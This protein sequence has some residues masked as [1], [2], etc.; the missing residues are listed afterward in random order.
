MDDNLDSH[1]KMRKVLEEGLQP[2]IDEITYAKDPFMLEYKTE[3]PKIG[4]K[5]KEFLDDEQF[6]FYCA[7]NRVLMAFLTDT[8][9]RFIIDFFSHG[10]KRYSMFME[11]N[12]KLT[13]ATLL[14]GSLIRG[15]VKQSEEISEMNPDN[16]KKM[17]EKSVEVWALSD[18]LDVIYESFIPVEISLKLKELQV[19]A[20]K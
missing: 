9:S 2:Q 7:Y 3:E 12:S 8:D 11:N 17:F 5:A 14:R 16:F 13:Q 10:V 15:L 19:E 1:E 4:E 18:V 20:N 6:R